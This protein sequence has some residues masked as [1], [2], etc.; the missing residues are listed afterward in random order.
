MDV[1]VIGQKTFGAGVAEIV[2]DEH[3]LVGAC[4][5]A[6]K[7]PGEERDPLRAFVED[8][9]ILSV[10]SDQLRPDLVP[11]CDLIVLAH[12]HVFVPADVRE[13][14]RSGAIG[15]HPS[16]LPLHRGRDSIRWAVHMGERVT[17]G[18]VYWIDDG[19]DTGPV[20]AQRHVLVRPDDTASSLWRRELFPLGL[21][22]VRDVL[23]QIE[24]GAAPR[25][26]QD[27]TL[28]TW[29]PSWRRSPLREV[30]HV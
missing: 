17:G 14:A 18:T 11:E 27:E 6:W 24:A 19:V 22:L 3:K 10:P 5:P 25:Q 29:E 13:R 1:F 23:S 20:A 8:F 21:E 15:Y 26:P 9:G 30:S 16:L 12:A 4:A 7:V 28:A 2:H